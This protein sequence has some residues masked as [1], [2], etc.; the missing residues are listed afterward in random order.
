MGN[1]EQGVCWAYLTVFSQQDA[2]AGCPVWEEAVT[3][4]ALVSPSPDSS[5]TGGNRSLFTK[6][7]TGWGARGAFAKHI[8]ESDGHK[9]QET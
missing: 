1:P 5:E 9:G 6:S 2:A 8:N 7:Y 3:G 4:P